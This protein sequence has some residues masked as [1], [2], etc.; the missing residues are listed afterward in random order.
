[1]DYNDITV[2]IQTGEVTVAG[3]IEFVNNINWARV[4]RTAEMFAVHTSPVNAI[5][6]AICQQYA[7]WKGAL[8]L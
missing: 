4:Q 8:T 1:M 3:P 6:S 7:A 2:N 5:K